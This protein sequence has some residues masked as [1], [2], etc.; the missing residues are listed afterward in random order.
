QYFRVPADNRDLN[1]SKY[2]E[3]GEQDLSQIEDYNSHNTERLD[4]VGMKQLLRKLDFIREIEA[5]N[6]IVPEGV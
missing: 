6:L 5:G 3:E 1:Y 4:V 2:F